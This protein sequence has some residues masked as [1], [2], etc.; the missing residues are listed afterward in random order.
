MNKEF[1]M[2][3]GRLAGCAALLALL[4]ASSSAAAK[5]V[6][7]AGVPVSAYTVSTQELAGVSMEEINNKL[8]DQRGQALAVLQSVIDDP[9]AKGEQI[10]AALDKKTQIAARMET[11]AA[12]CALLDHMGFGQTA[13]VMGEESLSI[14]APWQTAE[15]EQNRVRMIDAAASQ[16][17]LPAGAVKIILAKK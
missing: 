11:E 12:I 7:M 13:V 4:V 5:P 16:S 6:Q 10:S 2:R 1:V 14:V 9:K 15:N 17:G 8:D 3:A